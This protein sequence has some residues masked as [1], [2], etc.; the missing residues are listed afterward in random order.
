[1]LQEQEFDDRKL[2]FAIWEVA[3]RRMEWSALRTEFVYRMIPTQSASVEISSTQK[4][5]GKQ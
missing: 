3:R 2:C 1:M 4:G 5:R